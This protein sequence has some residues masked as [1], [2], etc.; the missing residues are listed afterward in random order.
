MATIANQLSIDVYHFNGA[1]N[2][3][4]RKETQIIPLPAKFVACSPGPDGAMRVYSKIL[5][6]PNYQ[7]EAYVG[8][9]VQALNSL[10]TNA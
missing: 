1:G 7:Q 6:G 8:Q 3:F 4:V 5:Y 10:V 2:A 9:S